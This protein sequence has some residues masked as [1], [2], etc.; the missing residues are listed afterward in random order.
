[1][2]NV[3][4]GSSRSRLARIETVL[5]SVPPESITPHGTS[6]TVL[7]RSA[8]SRSGSSSASYASSGM[9]ASGRT[10]TSQYRWSRIPAPV[11]VSAWPGSSDRIPSNSVRPSNEVPH[12]RDSTTPIRSTDRATDGCSSSAL[13]SDAN[14]KRPSRTV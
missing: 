4:R 5:E 7:I 3:W 12:S 11:T 8:S 10:G 13:A 1:M 2:V 6:P 9:A 14:R